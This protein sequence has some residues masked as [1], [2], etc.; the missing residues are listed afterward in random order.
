MDSLSSAQ[1]KNIW[2]SNTK[3]QDVQDYVYCLKIF[4]LSPSGLSGTILRLSYD[5]SYNVCLYAIN[6][7]L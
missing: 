1:I 2:L 4:I 6:H 7:S 5:D 3:K